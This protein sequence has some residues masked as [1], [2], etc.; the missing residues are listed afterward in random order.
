MPN[1]SAGAMIGVPVLVPPIILQRQYSEFV[2]KSASLVGILGNE[3]ARLEMSRDL[4][5]PRLIS[6]ELSV[7]T[8]ERELDAA[9]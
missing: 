5:L 3:I 7:A 1:L 8:A 9:A 4:L 6:G 2:D